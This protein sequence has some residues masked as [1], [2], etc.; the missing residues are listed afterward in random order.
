MALSL[1]LVLGGC[2]GKGEDSPDSGQEVAVPEQPQ[3]PAVEN[4][5]GS[6]TYL[7]KIMVPQEFGVAEYSTEQ[8]ASFKDCTA[9]ELKDKIHTI[10]DLVQY[11]IECGYAQPPG[12]IG[13]FS[14]SWGNYL[15]S[16]NRTPEGALRLQ[17]DSCG[18]VSNLARYILADDY[19]YA[20]F[21]LQAST[22]NNEENCGGHVYNY[23]MKDGKMLT[24]DF[25]S[26]I[27]YNESGDPG[28]AILINDLSEIRHGKNGVHNDYRVVITKNWYDDHPPVVGADL[29][30]GGSCWFLD[31]QYE[32]YMTVVWDDTEY[33]KTISDKISDYVYHDLF[34]DI[35]YDPTTIPYDEL[36]Y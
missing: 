29:N 30:S 5:E 36:D 14:Y 3:E 1:I 21:I 19:D 12:V 28:L 24:F 33:A 20:G 16:L 18:S 17:S 9:E 11:I 6:G 2:T 7:N 27:Y 32:D 23:F 22:V 34:E 10:S 25:T 26:P 15:I 4:A 13:D 8:I 31:S 35:G